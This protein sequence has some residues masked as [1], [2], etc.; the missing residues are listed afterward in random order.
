PQ[1]KAFAGV[2]PVK[3]QFQYT[4]LNHTSQEGN[5]CSNT[6]P[7]HLK[8]YIEN[9]LKT[10]IKIM[11]APL[12]PATV[13][14]PVSSP[15][16]G[17]ETSPLDETESSTGRA[18][19]LTVRAPD[20]RLVE[21]LCE[22]E[23]K[24]MGGRRRALG[25]C[26]GSSANSASN[27]SRNPR[28][29]LHP[30]PGATAAVMAA[31]G[32][33]ERS[34]LLSASHSGNVT[35]TA[36]PYLQE[37]S[38]R[39]ELP[40]PYTAIASPDASGIPVINCR[41]CQSLINLDGKLHQH[42]V[43]CTVC[44]E[45]TLA[46]EAMKPSKLLHHRETKHPALKDKSLESFKRKKCEHEEQKQL[47]KATTS[48]NVSALRA[49]F[50]VA[51]RIAKAKKPFTIG[52]ELILPTDKDVCRELLGEAAIQKAQK[53]LKN[54]EQSEANPLAWSL[55]I[56]RRHSSQTLPGVRRPAP[57][58]RLVSRLPVSGKQDRRLGSQRHLGEASA[59]RAAPETLR[60]PLAPC[61]SRE[62]HATGLTVLLP[63]GCAALWAPGAR[64]PAPRPPNAPGS[65]RL[66]RPRRRHPGPGADSRLQLFTAERRDAA[67]CPEILPD[68][69]AVVWNLKV[70]ETM[71]TK[72]LIGKP[73]QPARPVRHLT[74][75]PGTV[76]PFNFQNE[77]PCNT[78]YLQS[79][80]S[81]CKTNGMQAF[82]Q[83]LNE[84]HQ[85][86]VKKDI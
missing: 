19:A 57:R 21:R 35:P 11:R 33:D 17:F 42:V 16:G 86:P 47:L 61:T 13:V 2:N 37:S 8:T 25:G 36:P 85:S 28:L 18:P 56:Q 53:L 50:L 68:L 78:Q 55:P 84:Q 10:G 52:E 60:P 5:S 26:S 82:S 27:R 3:L 65:R 41:V 79:G 58:R 6:N 48:S 69:K 43:K 64:G 40:P 73:L 77:Y 44:N 1:C 32:V 49:S 15:L 45:A 38:P 39:A 66:P 4:Y 31:D 23:G 72:K 22:P 46:N 74:S 34:P 29:S 20:W 80:V 30:G 70:F 76:F 54:Y 63:P 14:C 24:T 62:T 51:N 7:L 71:E 83:G 75:P 67:A 12:V 81:R 59:P 9:V